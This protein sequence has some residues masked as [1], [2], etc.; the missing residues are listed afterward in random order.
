MDNKFL[1]FLVPENE[2][3]ELSVGDL[4]K[5]A[6][7]ELLLGNGILHVADW[8]GEENEG[9]IGTFVQLRAAALKPGLQ[10]DLRNAYEK[11]HRTGKSPGDFI[12]ALLKETT[13]VLKKEGLEMILLDRGNDSYYIGV[14][15][16]KNSKTI[17]RSSTDFWKFRPFGS[18]TGEVL[19]TVYCRCGSMNVWQLKRGEKL[20]DDV[21]QDCG[22]VLFDAQ[23]NSDFEVIRDYI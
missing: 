17:Q 20:T 3:A 9:G 14:I 22:T 6:L 15:E 4:S 11:A 23:G 1:S 2:F 12:P 18:Q 10:V 19:Y 5:D 8:K 16:Q 13:A 21:C 7:L